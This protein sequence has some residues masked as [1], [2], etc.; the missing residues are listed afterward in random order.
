MGVGQV[1]VKVGTHPYTLVIIPAAL[2]TA[3][4]LFDNIRNRLVIAEDATAGDIRDALSE[5]REHDAVELGR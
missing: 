1:I 4:V 5:C 3:R 2:A